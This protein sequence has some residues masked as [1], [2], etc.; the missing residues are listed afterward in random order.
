MTDHIGV[1]PG[2]QEAAH[3]EAIREVLAAHSRGLDRHEAGLLKAAYWPQAQVDYGAFKGPAHQFA[4][5]VGP[6]LKGAYELTQHLLGQ[7]FFALEGTQAHTET[8]VYARHLLHGGA[9]E[10]AFAGRYLDQLELRDQQ[11][12]ILHR[13][14]VMD[15]SL[16]LAVQDERNGDAFGALSKGRS[17]RDDPAHHLLPID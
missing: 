4:D 2:A 8:Y 5:L 10:L 6:A 12:K 16:R 15:W 11:W 9:E 3:R 14:V 13:Q 17:D 1:V 7:T